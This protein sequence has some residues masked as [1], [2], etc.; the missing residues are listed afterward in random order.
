MPETIPPSLIL[1]T[2][3]SVNGVSIAALFIGGLL[4]AAVG[5]VALGIIAFFRAHGEVHTEVKRPK[6]MVI[7][8][9]FLIAL[10][11]LILPL[12]IR[13]S[14]V[15]GV[16]TATEVSPVGVVYSLLVGP[17]FY[18]KLRCARW[19][20]LSQTNQTGRD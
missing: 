3:G 18:K 14:V 10:P 1:I 19:L 17:I 16:A 6:A 12:I 5:A 11:A 15:E 2:I 7:G 8:K 20:A 4:P 9:T 13:F